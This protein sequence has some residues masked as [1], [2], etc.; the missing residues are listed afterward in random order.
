MMTQFLLGHAPWLRLGA[1]IGIFVVMASWELLAP[2][3]TQVIGRWRRWPGN[4]GMVVV[5]SLIVRVIFPAAAVGVAMFAEARG[6]GLLPALGTPGWVAIPVAVV[7]L[8]LAIYLQHV[9]L[10]AVPLLWRLHRVHHADLEIDLTT[11]ARFHPLEILVSLVIKFVVIAALGAPAVAVLVFEVLLNGTSMF[12]H[13]NVRMPQRLDRMLRWLLVTPDM[14]RVHHSW[15]PDET[16]SNFGFNLP[17]WDRVFGTY[18]AQPRDG[19]IGMTIGINQFRDP[20]ELRLD[21]ML[22]QPLR[23]PTDSYPINARGNGSEP[24]DVP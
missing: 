21:R 8:D 3:C 15:Y 16:N 2:R 5:A 4:L 24:P 19:H 10:H 22:W 18:R 9:M 23:G 14:H 20:A 1:F 12:N 7:A 6:W 13:G 11:G 17:W